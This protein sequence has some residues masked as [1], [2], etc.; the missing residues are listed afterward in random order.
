MSKLIEFK[1]F[2]VGCVLDTVLTDGSIDRDFEVYANGVV[3]IERGVISFHVDFNSVG[4]FFNCDLNE[5]WVAKA[6]QALYEIWADKHYIDGGLGYYVR[7]FPGRFV[8]LK[9]LNNER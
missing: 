1:G 7:E 4:L 3:E 5:E 8:D 2:Y 6:K 9:E